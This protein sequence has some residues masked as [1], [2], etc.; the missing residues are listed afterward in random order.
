MCIRRHVVASIAIVA[1][2]V[3]MQ[4]QVLVQPAA[5]PVPSTASLD[6]FVTSVMRTFDVPGVSLAVVK[7]GRVDIVKGYG[8]RRLGESAP[9]DEHTLFGIASNTKIF[10]ATALG[11]LVEEGRL[12]WDDP[13]E[14][15]VGGTGLTIQ[16]S[17]T[18]ALRGRLEH[19]QQDTFVARWDDRELRADAFVT[20]ALDPDGRVAQARMRAVSPATDFSFD[21][22][23]LLLKPVSK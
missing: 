7:D 20:F 6:A 11:L 12:R 15:A 8:V 21:F 13:V 10:T 22:Q 2:T 4:A 5:Q 23:D 17:K 3:A 1:L 9:V 14:I 19:W 16:F 18:P